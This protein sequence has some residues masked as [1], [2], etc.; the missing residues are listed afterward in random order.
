MNLWLLVWNYLKSRPLNTA[1][2]IFLLGLGIAVVTIL[3]IV[4]H[5]VQ[6]KIS[7]NAR[8]I[9]LVVGAKGSPMQLILCN[10]FHVDFPTGNISLR[11]AERISR[12]RLVKNAIPLALGDSYLGYRIVGT[13]REYAEVYDAEIAQGTW[14]SKPLEVVVGARVAGVLKLSRGITF[15]SN[16]GLT[17]Q[18]ITFFKSSIH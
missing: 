10:I 11:E 8:G 12:N 15:S 6:E 1:L 2:N 16:H 4:N 5:Q 9:D 17:Q 7:T 13:T 3:I 18:G 14:W